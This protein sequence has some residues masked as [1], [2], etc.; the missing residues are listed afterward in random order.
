[1]TLV[2]LLSLFLANL[3]YFLQEILLARLFLSIEC[4]DTIYYHL[5]IIQVSLGELRCAWRT[6]W[7]IFL[8]IKQ[9]LT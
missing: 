1:M 5:L 8:T 9:V 7:L 6:F 3:V 2:S 4:T